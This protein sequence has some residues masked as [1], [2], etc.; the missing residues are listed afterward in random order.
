MSLDLNRINV[1]PDLFSSEGDC[2]EKIEMCLWCCIQSMLDASRYKFPFQGQY[3]S[4]TPRPLL[5][6]DLF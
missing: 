2:E 3:I 4:S 6:V 1:N 5:K